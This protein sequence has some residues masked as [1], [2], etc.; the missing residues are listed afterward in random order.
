MYRPDDGL[1]DDVGHERPVDREE[2]AGGQAV[3]DRPDERDREGRGDGD[4]GHPDAPIDARAVDHAS[5]A[6]SDRTAGPPGTTVTTVAECD[7]ARR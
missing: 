4:D 3:H 7:D 1:R 5:C 6:R 2:D